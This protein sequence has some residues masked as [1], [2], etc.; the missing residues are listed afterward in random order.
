MREDESEDEV[1]VWV[2]AGRCVLGR[3]VDDS[4]D[5]A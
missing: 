1:A 3:E 5:A 4:A 2:V